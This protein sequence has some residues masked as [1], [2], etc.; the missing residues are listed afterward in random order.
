LEPTRVSPEV[1]EALQEL[2][3]YL[4]DTMPPMMVAD[5]VEL[6]SAQPPVLVA[7]QI[8]GW[9]AAQYQGRTASLP[10][11]DY[12]FHA[13]KKI[14]LLAELR[15]VP[16]DRALRLLGG[17]LPL[18]ETFCPEEDRGLLRDN[19]SRLGSAATTLTSPVETIYRQVGSEQPLASR[20]RPGDAPGTAAGAPPAAAAP[21]AS[22]GP[23][24]TNDDV[25]RG[26][27]RFGLLVERLEKSL[28]KEGSKRPSDALTAQLLATAATASRSSRELEEN[29]ARLSRIGVDVPSGD[30]LF[31]KLSESLPGWGVPVNPDADETIGPGARG[32]VVG[33]MRRLVTLAP[34]AEEG[35]K[36]FREMVEAGVEQFNEG[37][38]GRAVTLFSLAEQVIR[39]ERVE[40][41]VA[42][43][44][45]ARSHETLDAARMR[46][47]AEKPE[48]HLGLKTILDFFPALRPDGLLDSLREERKREG[49]RLLLSLLEVHG[50]SAREAALEK[51]SVA[52]SAPAGETDWYFLRNLL[53]VLRKV[54]RTAET[55][56]EAEIDFLFR[57]SEPLLPLPLVK[58]A[59]ANLGQTRHDRA[60]QILV[61]R[62]SQLESSATKAGTVLPPDLLQLLDKTCIALA[63][64]A[65]PATLRAIV[66]HGLKGA[67]ATPGSVARLAHLGGHDLSPQEELVDR[68][69][70][71]L[72]GALPVKV[73]GIV[74]S[75]SGS[76][77]AE[78]RNL[79]KAL[80]GT[81]ALPV[82]R[83][84]EDV[85][86]KY[87]DRDFGREAR[88]ALSFF[89][90]PRKAAEAP[91]PASLAG[92][93]EV[94]GLPT[95]LQ[96]LE[97]TQA[98][99]LL[100]L[101]DGRGADVG[102][103]AFEGGKVRGA[104]FGILR[105]TDAFHQLLERPAA[106]S[107]AF[108][109]AASLRPEDVNFS[110][111][112]PVMGLLLEG[113]RR[114]DELQRS[115][116][117]IPD[118]SRLRPAGPKPTRLPQEDD[119]KL[120][121]AVWTKAS[122]GATAAECEAVA[123]TDAFRVRRLLVH[124]VEEGSLQVVPE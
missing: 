102:G 67:G 1:Q 18:L 11:S 91:G 83:L 63:R 17:I 71:A 122:Q 84:F 27:A 40:K 93:L 115:A 28:P 45:R 108:A 48:N 68:L 64:Q 43:A 65:T 29:L 90:Q 30:G 13:L 88:K 59:L 119:L 52:A 14:H 9:T 117:L 81:P 7:E 24:A 103:V 5:A 82:Q 66:D 76:A 123:A 99:G 107:F 111:P 22:P 79:V 21:L 95:L 69:L 121:S 34:D 86:R 53:Y 105:G 77:D 80:S 33:A 37:N 74:L 2:S 41:S 98:T 124:W 114:Y 6:L 32:S 57:L 38:L 4:S 26:L 50:P 3:Q 23:H 31:R 118:G 10:V 58:E 87:P 25:T 15:L 12:L 42:Q 89:E 60:E 8:R 75:S 16:T 49:R 62:L 120:L 39:R 70:K 85:A 47:Y 116:A 61:A 44:M 78:A 96:T 19:V 109:R 112:Q 54:P 55:P 20:G 51:L 106:A 56:S 73:L 72:R 46:T 100:A 35:A 92:D 97:Q 36:R 113:M 110:S 94:F 104:A 101:K